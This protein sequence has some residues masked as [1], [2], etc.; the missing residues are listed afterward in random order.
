MASRD[1]HGPSLPKRRIIC[2]CSPTNHPGSF[3]CSYHKQQS[4]KPMARPVARTPSK[5]NHRH[6]DASMAAARNEQLKEMKAILLQIIKPSSHDLHRRKNFQAR[7]SRFC[8]INDDTNRDAVAVSWIFFI[9]LFLL[10]CGCIPIFNFSPSF[11]SFKFLFL[12][13]VLFPFLL[14]LF[15]G[16]L[17]L[18]MFLIIHKV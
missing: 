8:S 5:S 15:F 1:G 3:R 9:T 16:G 18:R 2:L 10:L 6:R 11:Y 14:F 17:D 7:P 12:V 4:N 13:L